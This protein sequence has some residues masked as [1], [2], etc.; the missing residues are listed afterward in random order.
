[1][2]LSRFPG[3]PSRINMSEEEEEDDDFEL[4]EENINIRYIEQSNRRYQIPERG[5]TLPESITLPGADASKTSIIQFGTSL[6][7]SMPASYTRQALLQRIRDTLLLFG[8]EASSTPNT[9]TRRAPLRLE[10]IADATSGGNRA[11]PAEAIRLPAV[12]RS[13]VFNT[14]ASMIQFIDDH[15]LEQYIQIKGR[16]LKDDIARDLRD[17][18]SKHGYT[19]GPRGDFVRTGNMIIQGGYEFNDLITADDYVRFFRTPG[20]VPISQQDLDRLNVGLKTLLSILP[21]QRWQNL[22]EFLQQTSKVLNVGLPVVRL[23]SLLMK[24]SRERSQTYMAILKALEDTRI[25]QRDEERMNAILGYF[26]EKVSPFPR[27]YPRRE[28]FKGRATAT[29]TLEQAVRDGYQFSDDQYQDSITQMLGDTGVPIS[30]RKYFISLIQLYPDMFDVMRQFNN[31]NDSFA[32]TIINLYYTVPPSMVQVLYTFAVNAPLSIPDSPEKAQR[33]QLINS[34]PQSYMDTLYQIYDK[35][36]VEEILDMPQHPLE[37]YLFAMTKV[38]SHQLPALVS[39]FGMIVP[40]HLLTR[41]V[42]NYV[43]RFMHLYRNVITRPAD[44]QP[45][46]RAIRTQPDNVDDFINVLDRYTDQEIMDYF[47]YVER[48]ENRISLIN[49][50]FRM[51]REEGFMIYQEIDPERAIN[52]ETTLLTDVRDIIPPFLVF[53][54]PFKYRV[55][56]LDELVLA[57]H[58]EQGAN[59]EDIGIKF[60]K[61]GGATINEVYTIQQ[62]SRLQTLLPIMKAK[63]PQL[64]AVIDQ[65]LSKIRSGITLSKARNARVIQFIRDVKSASSEIQDIV[66]EIYMKIFY[67]GMY[68]RRWRGPGNRF[69]T[70]SSQTH[71]DFDP[72]P[73]SIATLDEVYSLLEQLGKLN[74]HLRSS[75]RTAPKVD[76]RSGNIIIDNF[77]LFDILDQVISGNY[78]IRQASRHLVLTAYYY[79]EA[80]FGESIPD[81]DP[82]SVDSID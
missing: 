68:M 18:L 15:N 25:F 48:F 61:I 57:F 2:S 22:E 6:G 58:E 19:I 59:Q 28:T 23:A 53:G 37:L 70:K 80:I 40:G 14:I 36:N 27:N 62:V 54:M 12:V 24:L 4:P 78:C 44:I 65:V 77:A 7:I 73:K 76:Y 34:L 33:R 10:L 21:Q 79:L 66:K 51:I 69:P 39:R 38:D 55:I 8:Y 82:Y 46:N 9:Y 32:R 64:T 42:R 49:N 29:M 56:E 17:F 3:S 31:S 63:N 74:S 67:A 72:E 11:V 45:M 5:I 26:R 1:M 52:T 60:T 81:F 47:G 41:Q 16:R 71:G 13:S 75:I 20:K 30:H 50:I 43:L 35:M